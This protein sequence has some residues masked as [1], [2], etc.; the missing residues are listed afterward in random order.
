MGIRISRYDGRGEGGGRGWRASESR[1][2]RLRYRNFCCAGD[3]SIRPARADGAPL[4]FKLVTRN[5]VSR[6]FIQRASPHVG[7]ARARARA[8]STRS[9]RSHRAL[10]IRGCARHEKK[11]ERMPDDGSTPIAGDEYR[12]RFDIESR[13]ICVPQ[14]WCLLISAILF[15]RERVPIRSP[16]ALL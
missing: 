15:A 1:G 10:R 12:I 2:E 7:D 9:A 4:N 16:F 8:S 13:F 5:A 14:R 6:V 3:C 11:R